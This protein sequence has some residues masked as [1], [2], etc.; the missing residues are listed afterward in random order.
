[1]YNLI[2]ASSSKNRKGLL[3]DLA[4]SFEVE[5]PICNEEEIKDDSSLILT[6]KRAIAKMESVAQNH[7]NEKAIVIGADTVV[8]VSGLIFGK[9]KTQNDAKTMILSYSGSSHLVIS[10]IALFN[11]HTYKMQQAS[12]VNKVFFKK[13]EEWEIDEYLKTDDWKGV[14]GGY[15][16]QGIASLFIEKIEGS[17][18]GVVGFPICEFYSCLMLLCG[19][20][21]SSLIFKSKLDL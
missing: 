9:P 21:I 5:E 12:S 17:Y 13:L 4:L 6:Q 7:K 16:I 1:M 11:T 19:D 20:E 18:S 15:K 8:D 10:S 3:S 14:A 2:L